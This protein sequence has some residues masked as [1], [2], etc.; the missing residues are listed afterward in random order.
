MAL[1][2]TPIVV[3]LDESHII[4]IRNLAKGRLDEM[5]IANDNPAII[6]IYSGILERLRGK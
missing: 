3:Y 1:P 4:A 2:N 6:R 5:I